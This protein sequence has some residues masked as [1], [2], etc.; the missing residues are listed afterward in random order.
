MSARAGT[1]AL[2]AAF[3]GRGFRHL[4]A[5]LLGAATLALFGGCRSIPFEAPRLVPAAGADPI[6]VRDAFAATLPERFDVECTLVF[7][8]LWHKAAILG[9]VRVDRAAARF[10]MVGLSHVGVQL[11]HVS[12]VNGREQVHFAMPQFRRRRGFVEALARDLAQ[13]YLGM[14]PAADAAATLEQ[15]RIVFRQ[16]RDGVTTEHVFGGTDLRLIEKRFRERGAANSRVMFF[17]YREHAGSLLPTGV[18]LSNREHHYRLV[19]TNRKVTVSSK[20]GT[21]S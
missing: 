5:V 3:E 2:A 11:L 20:S 10:E 8:W 19:L 12:V 6:R 1:A 9:V 17:E 16:R 14:L 13:V 7:N 4:G 15:R 21:D 18:V